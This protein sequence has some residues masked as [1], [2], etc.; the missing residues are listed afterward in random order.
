MDEA[1]SLAFNIFLFRDFTLAEPPFDAYNV[2]LI[3]KLLL[4]ET[5]TQTWS[6]TRERWLDTY[7][8]CVCDRCYGDLCVPKFEAFFTD[9]PTSSILP[10]EFLEDEEYKSGDDA[11]L[12][13]IQ[14]DAPPT[15]FKS[16][17]DL[18]VF[19]PE[20]NFILVG[21]EKGKPSQIILPPPP[22]RPPPKTIIPGFNAPPPVPQKQNSKKKKKKNNN[23][24]KKRCPRK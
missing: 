9:A 5:E 15:E 17:F 18:P 22:L 3:E 20:K 14:P 24:K 16:P 13:D 12:F 4:G 21:A 10:M 8:E 7:G 6:Q 11:P 19:S 2:P 1:R 23:S